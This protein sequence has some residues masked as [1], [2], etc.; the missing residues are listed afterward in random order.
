MN[1]NVGSVLRYSN[2]FLFHTIEGDQSHI[3][4]CNMG[5]QGITEAWSGTP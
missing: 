2:E 4:Y 3:Y 1:A 5:K